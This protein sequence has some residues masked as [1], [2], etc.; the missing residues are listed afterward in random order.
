M[1]VLIVLVIMSL[2]I[3]GINFII[4]LGVPLLGVLENFFDL[5]KIGVQDEDHS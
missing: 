1:T 2:L 3:P 5:K 4:L